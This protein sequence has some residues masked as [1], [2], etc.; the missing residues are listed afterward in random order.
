MHVELDFD[1]TAFRCHEGRGEAFRSLLASVCLNVCMCPS[2]SIWLYSRVC[3]CY[4]IA[5]AIAV[6]AAAATI[7]ATAASHAPQNPEPPPP[8]CPLSSCT[9]RR[10]EI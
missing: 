4:Y 8:N 9:T 7:V 3:V 10:R 6:A 2:V 1:F 5:A